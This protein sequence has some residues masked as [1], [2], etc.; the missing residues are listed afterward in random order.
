MKR[1]LTIVLA[2]AVAA[3]ALLAQPKLVGHRGCRHNEDRS[4]EFMY[5]ENTLP[6]LKYAQSLG[7]DA[8]EFDVQLTADDQ[9]IVFH[10][11]ILPGTKTSVQDITF[12][13]ARKFSLP[14]GYRMPSLEEWFKQAKKHPEVTIIIETKAQKNREKETLLVEKVM[15][16]AEKMEMGKQL[17]YTTFSEWMCSEIHRI[18]PSAKVLFLASGLNVPDAA[19]AKEKGY[20]GISYDINGWLNNPWIADQ[21]R[22][23]GIETTLWIANDYE[24]V[25]WAVRHKI[26]YVSTDH[27]EKLKAYLD[28]IKVFK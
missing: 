4:G 27:P 1:I 18:N 5:Y 17:E 16:L 13:E 7:I 14:G 26:D 24:L 11:P 12:D 20:N 15:A 3:P 28:G 22:E 2:L 23:L 21:A 9:V 25:D 10:G 6:A 19:Y 8:V